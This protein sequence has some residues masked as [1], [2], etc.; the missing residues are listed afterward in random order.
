MFEMN[1]DTK[2]WPKNKKGKKM[3]EI[4]WLTFAT[5]R[6]C[7][8]DVLG[9]YKGGKDDTTAVSWPKMMLR[10]CEDF[11]GYKDVQGINLY[12]R[13]KFTKDHN[14]IGKLINQINSEIGN[15]YKLMLLIDSDL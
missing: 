12:S 15:G 4:D 5:L 6:S 3:A 13:K 14:I 9:V 1:P 2:D 11:L 8:N 10:L 7:A